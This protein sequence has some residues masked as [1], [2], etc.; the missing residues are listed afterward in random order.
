MQYS[1]VNLTNTHKLRIDAEYYHPMYLAIQD[2]LA[3]QKTTPLVAYSYFVKKGIFDISPEKYK[4]KGVPL[5]RTS[6]IKDP[7]ID[8]SSTVFI[9]DETQEEFSNTELSS[10][11]LVFTKIGAYI[12][13]VSYLP[14][15]YSKYNF[16]QNVAG[17]KIK[18]EKISS[19]YLLCYLLSRYGK[20]QILR[21][22][23]LSGQ[24]KLELDDIRNIAI[25][26]CSSK[27]QKKCQQ[28]IRKIENYKQNVEQCFLSAD[29]MLRTNLGILNQTSYC[30]SYVKNFSDIQNANRLDAEYFQPKYDELIKKI[31]SHPNG[32]DTLDDIVFT[33]KGVEIGSEAYTDKGYP[34]IRVSNLNKF[35]LTDN[36]QQYLSEEL[37]EELKTKYQ[38]KKNDIILSKDGT[39]GIAY[40]LSEEPEKMILSGGL[41]R[42]ELKNTEDYLPEYLTLV[43]NS[44]LVQEQIEQQTSGA[45][46][47]HWLVDDIKSTI[48][49]KLERAKQQE[50]VDKIREATMAKKQSKQLLEIAKHGVEKAIEENEDIAMQWIDEQLKQIGVTL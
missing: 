21:N 20:T 31:K 22:A 18:K 8:F 4:E 35:G 40:L 9:D 1:I 27:I 38:P 42:L 19:E 48:I 6:E 12:G 26:D 30:Q 14:S 11:D 15:T 10:G 47:L 46:I 32:W 3:T 2:I 44:I 17:I 34:F 23:M 28:I 50:I 37:Y 43:L 24:G 13:D 45:V 33:K 25:V 49:P 39:P 5:I 7:M 16:S 29:D 41:L 36:N